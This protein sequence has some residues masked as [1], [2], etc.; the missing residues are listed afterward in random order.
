MIIRLFFKLLS[1]LFFSI[2]LLMSC[3]SS[4]TDDKK[5]FTET[6]SI[7]IAV[8]ANM[9]FAMDSIAK[10]FEKTYGV[11][12]NLSSNSSGMLT[13]QIENG[14]PYD[15]FISANMLYPERLYKKELSEKPTVYAKG[16]LILVYDKSI[17]ASSID[18]VLRLSNIHKIA[19][20]NTKTAPYGLAAKEYLDN[21]N[22]FSDFEEKIIYG[23][24]IGQVNQYVV[25]GAVDAGFTSY[26][27]LTKYEADY[28][29]IEVDTT[30]FNPIKQGY[31]MLN[32]N[33]NEARL[34]VNFLTSKECKLILTHFGYNID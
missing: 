3:S 5:I 10:E 15:V 12:C 19:I 17:N 1:F 23:E 18:E 33:S 31:C 11:L 29:F 7:Q 20:A 2:L 21:S 34:F 26:S 25:S 14:A 30:L 28:N 22:M 24:S 6:K 32:K 4:N 8:A 16:R 27:F 9:S 13:A